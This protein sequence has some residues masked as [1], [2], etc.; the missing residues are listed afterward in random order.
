M[1]HHATSCHA[2]ITGTK[3][4]WQYIVKTVALWF[5]PLEPI[6]VTLSK[7]APPSGRQRKKLL[8][9]RFFCYAL[10]TVVQIADGALPAGG[11]KKTLGFAIWFNDIWALLHRFIVFFRLICEHST[12]VCSCLSFVSF[13]CF[14]WCLFI[15]HKIC[16]PILNIGPDN[17]QHDVFFFLS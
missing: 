4:F 9:H 6:S 7:T 13:C 12:F 16:Q 5:A 3:V 15:H 14:I 1:L 2:S 17:P 8:K 11:Q 10:N